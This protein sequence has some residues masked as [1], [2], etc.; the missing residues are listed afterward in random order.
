MHGNVGVPQEDVRR[1]IMACQAEIDLC[2]ELVDADGQIQFLSDERAAFANKVM[3]LLDSYEVD[4]AA[5][6][7][8]V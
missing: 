4:P 5:T 2:G 6:E 8:S 3:R 1:Q 7:R